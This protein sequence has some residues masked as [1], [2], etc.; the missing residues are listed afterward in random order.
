MRAQRVP[1][2]P[3]PRLVFDDLRPTVD[4]QLND[5]LIVE[6]GK[7]YARIG[8]DLPNLGRTQVGDEGQT[9]RCLVEAAQHDGS[10]LRRTVLADGRELHQRKGRSLF[11]R[12]AGQGLALASLFFV[13]DDIDAGRLARPFA[14]ELRVG[15]DFYLVSPRKPRHP[16]PTADVRSWLLTAA[17]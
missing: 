7:R 1:E 8:R 14:T 11:D 10:D 6:A 5:P 16:E 15:S 3:P 2:V 9:R 4:A 12:I 17:R 13:Q